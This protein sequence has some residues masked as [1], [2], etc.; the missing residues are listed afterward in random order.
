MKKSKQKSNKNCKKVTELTKN[1]HIM[2]LE[3]EICQKYVLNNQ[4]NEKYHKIYQNWQLNHI[5]QHRIKIQIFNVNLQYQKNKI[6][7]N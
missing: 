5:T 6:G 7:I 2:K 4:Q 3:F 1:K